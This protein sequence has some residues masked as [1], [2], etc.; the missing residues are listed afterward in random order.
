MFASRKG[1]KKKVAHIGCRRAEAQNR[2]RGVSVVLRTLSHLHTVPHGPWCSKNGATLLYQISTTNANN[3]F[4]RPET[5]H[6][7]KN[8]P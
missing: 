3:P 6:E 8:G 2:Y 5:N 1:Q 7:F 4:A